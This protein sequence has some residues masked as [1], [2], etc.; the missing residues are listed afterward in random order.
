MDR[1]ERALFEERFLA[2]SLSGRS[3]HLAEH[4]DSFL[5]LMYS[6][7]VYNMFNNCSFTNQHLADSTCVS[8]AIKARA[9]QNSRGGNYEGF[10]KSD[11]KIKGFVCLLF[12]SSAGHVF[13]SL[14]CLLSI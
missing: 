3:F 12:P 7:D 2:K 13:L 8:D 1:L 14:H 6:F 11:Y 4:Y 10:D 5:A 9:E